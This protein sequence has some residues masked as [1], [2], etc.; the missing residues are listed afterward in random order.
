MK[1]G[2]YNYSFELVSSSLIILTL[3]H[4]VTCTSS[5]TF[6][7]WGG[8]NGVDTSQSVYLPEGKHWVTD[9]IAKLLWAFICM[10]IYLWIYASGFLSF[11]F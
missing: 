7:Y 1:V 9:N 5:H 2:S 11:V 10:F 8:A 6:Y 4:V 3:I